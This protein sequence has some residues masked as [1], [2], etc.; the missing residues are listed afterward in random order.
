[1]T[2]EDDLPYTV[3]SQWAYDEIKRMLFTPNRTLT[4]LDRKHRIKELLAK[5]PGQRF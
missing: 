2:K 1:M 3:V 4:Q 5:P